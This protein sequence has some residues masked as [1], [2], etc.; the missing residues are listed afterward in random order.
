MRMRDKTPWPMLILK[1]KDGRSM[2][3]FLNAL[4][5][6]GAL[7]VIIR[8]LSFYYNNSNRKDNEKDVDYESY[9]VNE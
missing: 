6:V 8:F 1:R 7:I 5:T 2:L 4:A 9:Y 3:T